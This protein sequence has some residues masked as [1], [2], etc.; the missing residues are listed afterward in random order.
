MSCKTTKAYTTIVCVN[1][2]VL[3]AGFA[4]YY[5]NHISN[6]IS[7][8]G[9]WPSDTV[10][11]PLR[12]WE[13]RQAGMIAALEIPET[14]V[15][16]STGQFLYHFV[17]AF[18]D[19]SWMQSAAGKYSCAIESTA[20]SLLRNTTVAKKPWKVVAWVLAG[21]FGRNFSLALRD[22]VALGE[23]KNVEVRMLDVNELFRDTPLEG[24][25]TS[26]QPGQFPRGL[27]DGWSGPYGFYGLVKFGDAVRLALLYKMG[28]MYMDLD[29]IV[30]RDVSELLVD[31][32]GLQSGNSNTANNPEAR[33]F[34][35]N[36]RDFPDAPVGL[37]NHAMMLQEPG[38]PF[39]LEL[40]G[41]FK[42]YYGRKKWSTAG[43]ILLTAVFGRYCY[44][45]NS[46]SPDFLTAKM[47]C[48]GLN[49]WPKEIASAL[50]W[51]QSSASAFNVD[52]TTAD[53]LEKKLHESGA[54]MVHWGDHTSQSQQKE[55]LQKVSQS[56][57][58][59]ATFNSSFWGR[60]CLRYCPGSANSLVTATKS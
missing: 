20:R 59:I 10:G 9:L 2:G 35:Y 7:T 47:L 53:S 45:Q 1:V 28:G 46:T 16:E 4:L 56:T 26:E 12:V 42:A 54:F 17:L 32:S 57:D 41:Q 36:Y 37:S 34:S 22:L 5:T 11:S 50:S 18:G 51:M 24:F 21:G 52:P 23:I 39:F 60:A 14:R 3:I 31:P 38:H 8:E 49:V 27:L 33:H 48:T 40:L 19:E 25:Y 30:L 58:P 55:L 29:H 44:I 13:I 6:Y 43:P 15:N